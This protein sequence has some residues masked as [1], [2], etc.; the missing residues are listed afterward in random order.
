MSWSAI[1]QARPQMP[2]LPGAELEPYP[3]LSGYGLMQRVTR[4]ATPM[5]SELSKLGFRNHQV[6]DVLLATQ[7][8]SKPT[9]S[10]LQILGLQS[11]SLAAYWRP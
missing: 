7:R 9:L 10:L 11:T 8:R 2:A 5:S 3:Y 6:A 1:I 4:L